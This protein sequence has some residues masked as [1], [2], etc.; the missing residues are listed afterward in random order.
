[1]LVLEKR[2]IYFATELSLRA[3][4][5]PKRMTLLACDRDRELWTDPIFWACIE[6]SFRILSQSDLPDLT[7]SPWI[8]DF[9]RWTQPEVVI[10]G[11]DQKERGLWGREWVWGKSLTICTRT[12][13]VRTRDAWLTWTQNR[14]FNIWTTKLRESVLFDCPGWKWV[15]QNTVYSDWCTWLTSCMNCPK[16]PQG[17]I[18]SHECEKQ[19]YHQM[20]C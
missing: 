17:E 5:S 10:L 8:A 16:C 4:S 15:S 18:L 7:G 11:A 6:Y 14:R 20:P 9:R 13:H 3:S 12:R 2:S 1:M 19:A